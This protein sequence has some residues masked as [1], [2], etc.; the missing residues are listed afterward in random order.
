MLREAL[1]GLEVEGV[2]CNRALLCEV[3]AHR[4]FAA[5]AVTTRWLE[6]EALA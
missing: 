2:E 3:L 4:D 1:A 6:E 5:G